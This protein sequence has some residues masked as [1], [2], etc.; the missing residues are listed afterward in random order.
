MD[1]ERVDRLGN[2]P[3]SSGEVPP[4]RAWST[5]REVV[6]VALPNMAGYT[7]PL[8]NE[9]TNAVFIG[10]FGDE[11]ELAAVGIGNMMQNCIA[12]SVAFGLCAAMD[13]LVSQ[14]F[15]ANRHDSCCHALQRARLIMTLQLAWMVPLLYFSEDLLLAIRQDPNVARHAGDYNRIS[16]LGLWALFQHEASR[17][18]LINRCCT[19]PLAVISAVA[20]VLHIAWCMIFIVH[21]G[22][23]NRGAGFANC[24]TWW[25]QFMLSS[26]YLCWTAPRMGFRRRAVLLIQRDGWREWR[27]YMRL[28]I[29]ATVQLCSEW[30]FWELCALIVGYLGNVEMA[31]H[32]STLNFVAMTF[33]PSCGIQ[34]STATLVGN[35]LGANLPM[36]ARQTAWVCLAFDAAQWTV[37]AVFTEC[38]SGLVASAYCADPEV[39]LVMR[40]LLYIYGAAGYFDTL[41]NVMGGAVRGL[42][43]PEVAAAIYLF[44][45]YGV[46]LPAGCALA[47]WADL[48]V[49]G[50]WWSFAIGTGLAT[51]LFTR[52]LCQTDWV[53]AAASAGERMRRESEAPL[54]S[55]LT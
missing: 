5:L 38:G 21:L 23:G 34:A 50:I 24:V 29:P 4:L 16:L 26:A 30:W 20:S 18:F 43:R 28:A 17:K 15:G 8:V 9:L 46:M 39:Q 48:R 42:G 36:K 52:F 53:A 44:S 40:R 10:H 2:S 7:L 41:Q 11:A 55:S 33:M 22:M 27:P 51:A 14:A 45:F 32:V 31:A 47:F 25:L 3:A 19:I 35:A 1:V 13:T 49:Y 6:S 37:I 12:V 54:C